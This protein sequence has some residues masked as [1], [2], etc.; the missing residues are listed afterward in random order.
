MPGLLAPLSSACSSCLGRAG[1]SSSPVG[2]PLVAA[3]HADAAH[4]TRA[5]RDTTETEE[6]VKH[7]SNARHARGHGTAHSK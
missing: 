3:H 5:Y 6:R 7:M 4:E 1:P 2:P